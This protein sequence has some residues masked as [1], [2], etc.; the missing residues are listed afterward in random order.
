ML[1]RSRLSERI[2]VFIVLMALITVSGA[3][4]D[5]AADFSDDFWFGIATA[6]A[7]QEDQLDDVWQKFA[8]EGHVRAW[9]DVPRAEERLR[10]WSE[11]ETDIRLAAE[12]GVQVYRMGVDWGRLVPDCSLDTTEP[13]SCRIQNE[14]ALKHYEE[15]LGLVRRYGMKVMLTLFHHSFPKW[16]TWPEEAVAAAAKQR[17]RDKG[18][19]SD[20]LNAG[21]GTGLMWQ[22]PNA[23]QLFVTFGLDVVRR[24][25][26]LVDFWV[27]FN[28][29]VIFTALSHCMGMWPPGPAVTSVPVQV[30]CLTNPATGSLKAQL[31]MVAAHRQMYVLIRQAEQERGWPAAPVGVA[32]L[33]MDTRPYVSYGTAHQV[34]SATEL[35]LKLFAR[36]LFIDM[37]RDVLD[38]CGINYYGEEIIHDG[39]PA[40]L[41][42]EVEYSS[43]G[44][45]I[46]ATGMVNVLSQFHSR[47]ANDPEARFTGPE[48]YGYVITEN[49]IADGSD[50]LRPAYIT[51]HLVAL[52]HARSVLDIP[53][54]G[55]IHWTITDNWEWADGYCP[56]FGLVSVDR[57]HPAMPRT[58]R[59]SYW[60]YKDI[61]QARRVSWRQKEEAWANA[62]RA[63][64]NNQTHDVCRVGVLALDTP[65]QARILAGSDDPHGNPIDWRFNASN[66]RLDA[67][68]T[69]RASTLLVASMAFSK[70]TGID[71]LA[72]TVET[73]A[74]L[75]NK[76][77]TL[78]AEHQS[79]MDRWE[80]QRADFDRYTQMATSVNGT[81]FMLDA[82]GHWMGIYHYPPNP[83]LPPALPP[84]PPPSNPY[85][86]SPP[87][88]PPS[89][90][91]PP[92]VFDLWSAS[93]LAFGTA[94]ALVAGTAGPAVVLLTGGSSGGREDSDSGAD[95][96]AGHL[97]GHPS[98][99]LDGVDQ[100]VFLI[101]PGG[102]VPPS[103]APVRPGSV[104]QGPA[105]VSSARPDPWVLTVLALAAALLAGL[106]AWGSW[107][108][109]RRRSAT[110]AGP[111]EAGSAGKRGGENGGRFEML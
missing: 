64:A 38:F 92:V 34:D 25:G 21:S 71:P 97:A 98:K 78:M 107:G 108:A 1:P 66:I 60:L 74:A 48:G 85:P 53:V 15:I 90:S 23:A 46:S 18:D 16:G 5:A 68:A 111:G 95:A 100:R 8:R 40:S 101:Q 2:T 57:S 104:G 62:T 83:P 17:E 9:K 65:L 87:P 109:K 33:L 56:K 105:V 103:A 28:E 20:R 36:Y 55:Y 42:Q 49:G 67:E 19:L 30:N 11:P 10:A 110:R 81:G 39:G 22:H 77:D 82:I 75:S 69:R 61:V 79:R 94:A 96:S 26:H 86:P 31:N 29:P 72:D 3:A 102:L 59:L 63:A 44:R 88:P 73:M 91:H 32:H 6:P 47:Y 52:A 93:Q 70:A 27:I 99:H 54:R 37:L 13:D 4:A 7:H 43:N 41:P 84:F 80:T 12:T 50:L 106:S 35:F 58:P 89:P 76:W 24:L 51:E 14:A 45:G